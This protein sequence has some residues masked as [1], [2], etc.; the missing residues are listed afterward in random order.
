VSTRLEVRAETPEDE[1][2][3][4]TGEEARR[5]LRG[6][7]RRNGECERRGLPT[8][9]FY[10]PTK[11][12]KV[13]QACEECKVRKE[14]LE[15]V[16][17]THEQ[18]GFW[19]G[20]TVNQRK[21]I[22]KRWL[23]EHVKRGTFPPGNHKLNSYRPHS[24]DRRIMGLLYKANN[25]KLVPDSGS[26]LNYLEEMLNEKRTSIASR[27][28]ALERQGFINKLWASKRRISAIELTQRGLELIEAD[29]SFIE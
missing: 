6:A 17:I 26:M 29:P 5:I 27:L 15:N 8:A 28:T 19:A 18:F 7:W 2:L 9:W 11:Y 25:H 22:Y 23:A 10:N 20:Y 21:P 16:L 14:C 24:L 3:L 4:A 12:S 13:A 1:F